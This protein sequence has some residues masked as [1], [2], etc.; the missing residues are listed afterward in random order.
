MTRWSSNLR[1]QFLLA[2]IPI[3]GVFALPARAW[4][5][6][7]E[8][9]QAA[10]DALGSNDAL[11]ARL[12]AAVHKLPVYCWMADQRQ[13]LIIRADE[14]FYADDY[15]LF[16]G[17]SRHT[18]HLCPDV[19]RTYVPHFRR[20]LQALRTETPVNA[21]RWIGSLT[22][23][24]EDTGSP[25]HAAEIRGD[26]HSKMEN[27][28]DAK[29]I[30]IA[31][32]VPQSFG[33]TEAAAE[34]GFLKRMDGLIEFSKARAAR[35][36]ADVEAGNRAAVE[37]V[38]LESALE[39]SRVLADLLHTLGVLTRATS[40]GGELRGHVAHA[41]GLGKLDKLPA[42]IVLLDTLYSTL[43]DSDGRFSFEHIPPGKYR[44]ACITPG[45]RIDT[46]EISVNALGAAE[47]AIVEIPATHSG[48]LVRDPGF[49][50]SWISQ[51]SPDGWYAI[52]RSSKNAAGWQGEWLPLERGQEYRLV[53][54]W[55][56]IPS[57]GSGAAAPVEGDV[58]VRMKKDLNPV[59][60]P[61]IGPAITRP[62]EE[63]KIVA[64]PEKG[65][66][67]Q[68]FIRTPRKPGEIIESI[69]LLPATSK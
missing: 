65:T 22:H 62:L 18:D 4:G 40:A 34:A 10:L 58:F 16:P 48:G 19:K 21:A 25:P 57:V 41:S 31:G 50:L 5:P 69:D 9:T 2:I 32:Y 1:L 7:P 28:V 53:I 26:V 27:W 24:V 64:T 47:S 30:S 38:V 36:R 13:T 29:K 68:I 37:P 52:P 39:T 46:R 17:V 20:A 15:L 67:A 60:P 45:A 63:Q 33:D 42:K 35:C 43:A 61:A 6:H 12:G 49:K 3:L 66:W 54:R 44:L 51:E 14:T 23:F 11:A 8:I 55:K 59:L 56:Q